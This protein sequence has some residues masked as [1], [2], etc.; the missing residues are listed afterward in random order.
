MLLNIQ[1]QLDHN[2]GTIKTVLNLF[3]KHKL[4]VLIILQNKLKQIKFLQFH[5]TNY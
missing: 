2:N 1:A 4:Q 5:M 3:L